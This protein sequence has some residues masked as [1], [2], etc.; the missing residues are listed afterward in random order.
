MIES[1]VCASIVNYGEFTLELNE[2]ET[3]LIEINV[4]S[5]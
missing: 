1:T 4:K 3:L 5:G 2:N